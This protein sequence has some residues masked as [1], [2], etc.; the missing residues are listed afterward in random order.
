MDQKEYELLIKNGAN[1]S[2]LICE[3]QI[4]N[5]PKQLLFEKRN[6]DLIYCGLIEKNGGYYTKYV[7]A[8]FPYE[9]NH[10]YREEILEPGRV[11]NTELNSVLHDILK[12]NMNGLERKLP[13]KIIAS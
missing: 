9:I 13:A 1:N 2:Y 12:R 7:D 8:V 11:P 10:K 4:Q 6:G 3:V 5:S